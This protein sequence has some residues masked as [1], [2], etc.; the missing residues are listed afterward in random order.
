MKKLLFSIAW[1]TLCLNLWAQGFIEN[2]PWK[3]VLQQAQQQKKLIFVDCYTSWCGP[4]KQLASE[5][6]PQE[7]V[8]NFLHEHF[9]ACKYDMEKGDGT[10]LYKKYKSHIPGFPTMLIIDP[11]NETVVHKV[12]GFT[13]AD[14]LIQALQDGLNGKTL[15]AYQ[16]RYDAGERSLDFMQEYCQALDVAHEVKTKEQVV[17]NFVESM[18]LDSLLNVEIYMLYEPY[19]NDAYSKQFEFVVEHI[20][21]YQRMPDMNHYDIEFRLTQTLSF[22]VGYIINA[23]LATTNKDSLTSLQEKETILKKLLM[24]DIKGFNGENAKL[25]INDIRLQGDMAALDAI[26]DADKQLRVTNDE[27]LFRPRMY[28]YIVEHADAKTQRHLIEKYL[29]ILQQRQ[30]T[31]NKRA[32]DKISMFTGN[33]YDILAIGY[34]RLGDQEKSETCAQEFER[35]LN[36]KMEGMFSVYKDEKSRKELSDNNKQLIDKL[37]AK[38]GIK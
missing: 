16:K 26:L 38:I 19:L 27:I 36:I 2:K 22:A 8:Q 11:T 28:A 1:L 4:C 20:N 12:V 13:E 29:N 5:V 35:R 15:T 32:G 6:F 7:K 17:R 33:D 37:H 9:V 23:S 34:H 25:V 24:H 30:D 18:P 31:E 21:D 10:L 14:E 3:E